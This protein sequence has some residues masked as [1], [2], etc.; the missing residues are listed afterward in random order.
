MKLNKYTTFVSNHILAY[1]VFYFLFINLLFPFII[2]IVVAIVS[3]NS[4]VNGMI[5]QQYTFLIYACG[6][7]LFVASSFNLLKTQFQIFRLK[8]RENF[9]IIFSG[10]FKMLVSGLVINTAIEMITSLSTSSNQ[11]G[12]NGI[13]GTSP[14]LFIFISLVFAP[15]CEELLFR[16]AYYFA[17]EKSGF[18]ERLATLI[19]SVSFGF[20]HVLAIFLTL[21]TTGGNVGEMLYL[22]TYSVMGYFFV[23]TAKR[24]NNIWGSIILHMIYNSVA[25]L[26]V[27]M[28]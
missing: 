15:F 6:F 25:V 9:G 20:I 18:S 19:S 4:I 22:V 14:L 3:P 23:Q 17:L 26:A 12:L 8:L 7:L 21:V 13:A 16:G 28:I 27:L 5:P 11:E 2:G 10:L 1:S 24:T